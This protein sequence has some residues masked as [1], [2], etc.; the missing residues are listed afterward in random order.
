MPLEVVPGWLCVYSVWIL[1]YP[2]S[3]V[4]LR[5]ASSPPSLYEAWGANSLS[6]YTELIEVRMA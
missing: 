4:S 6:N 1:F 5:Q 3:L 2:V